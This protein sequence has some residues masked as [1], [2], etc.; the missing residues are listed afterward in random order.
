MKVP[1]FKNEIQEHPSSIAR[2][3]ICLGPEVDK[4]CSLGLDYVV[5]FCLSKNQTGE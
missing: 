4:H 2:T 3:G 1:F 5:L